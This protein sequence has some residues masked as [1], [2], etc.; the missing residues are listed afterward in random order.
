MKC[1][2]CRGEMKSATA[3]FHVDRNGYHLMLDAVPA[4]V[5]GQCGEAHFEGREVEAIQA[6]IRILD[7]QT[8]QLSAHGAGTAS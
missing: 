3:P 6:T 4:W 1:L 2:H 8:R 7:R 5:C